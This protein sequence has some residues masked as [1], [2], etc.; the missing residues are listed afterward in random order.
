[1]WALRSAITI[2]VALQLAS[3][4]TKH[5]EMPPIDV[6]A[7]REISRTGD[8]YVVWERRLNEE[9]QIW[10][11]QL[12][13]SGLHRLVPHEDER[14]HTCPKISPDGRSVAYL[15][16]KRG[17]VAYDDAAGELR[18]IDLASRQI[19]TLAAAARTYHENRAVVWFDAHRLCYVAPAGDAMELNIITL[20]ATQLTS[21]THPRGGWLIDRTKHFA[22]TGEPEFAPFDAASGVITSQPKQGGCQPYF[23]S[24]GRW[25]FWMGGAGGPLNAMHLDT[26]QISQVLEFN[27]PRLPRAQNYVYFPM[28][29]DG[30]R[31]LAFAASKDD[32]DHFSAEYDIYV[33]RLDPQT[34]DVIGRPVRFSEHSGTDRYPDVWQQELPLG[35]HFAEGSTQLT[36]AAP[37]NAVA[38]WSVDGSRIATGAALTH[39]FVGNGDHWV[40]AQTSGRRLMGLVHIRRSC[41]PYVTVTRRI[42]PDRLGFTF[43]E[44]VS[45]EHARARTDG[46]QSL[47][48]SASSAGGRQC[49]V[50]LPAGAKSVTLSGIQDLAQEA[51]IM[52]EECFPVALP[53]WPQIQEGLVFAWENKHVGSIGMGAPVSPE[54]RGKAFWSA[55]GGLD[56]R[57]GWAE[58]P[59]VGH[60][61][62]QACSTSR[63]VSIE[64]IIRPLSLP[65]D[66]EDRPI[67][68]VETPDGTPQ[69]T[70]SQ[71]ASTLVLR[72]PAAE[73]QNTPVRDYLLAQTR[74]G[75]TY[76]FI[77]SYKDG[78]VTMYLNGNEVWVRPAVG[79]Q[80]VFPSG[81][82]VFRIGSGSKTPE[83]SRWLGTVEGLAVYDR[84]LGASE[85]MSHAS[86][87]APLLAARAQERQRK[88]R[89]R[90]LETSRQPELDDIS[91]YREALTTHLYEVL[92]TV[93]AE[94]KQELPAGTEIRV[95]HWVWV[96]GQRVNRPASTPGTEFELFLD[97]ASQHGEVKSLVVRND[98]TRGIGAEDYFDASNW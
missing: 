17:S 32:H 55:S 8:G 58:F 6:A 94:E 57:G 7:L 29:S 60:L 98:L 22:T 50:T 37:G 70:L 31:L 86:A 18:L 95:L 59:G 2:A 42:P 75:T 28:I 83:T 71:R 49:E 51:D 81:A 14:E 85:A 68:C 34:L 56:V 20:K 97:P 73:T 3:C 88:V 23:T 12:D 24:D 30:M 89:L 72:V 33:A 74:S 63:A 9:W 62:A 10:I 66:R 47:Q 35:T 25:G 69:L 15:S 67:L 5:E 13:G 90:L 79:G 84:V 96:N 91:P 46:G 52:P 64:A 76:H 36:L 39:R 21:K 61:M 82:S 38:E 26:R 54:L 16:K 45:L 87:V 65:Y 77:L 78:H 92:P 44:P 43:S 48:F 41:A 19:R 53:S 80:M 11:K 40:E 27:D 4:D 1:M 93:N